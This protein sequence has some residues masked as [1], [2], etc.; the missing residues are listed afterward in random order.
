MPAALARFTVELADELALPYADQ[1]VYPRRIVVDRPGTVN[2][3]FPC[4]PVPVLVIAVENQ[5]VCAW[6]VPLDGEDNPPVLVGGDLGAGT[7]ATV[8]YAADVGAYVRSRR[9]DHACLSSGPLVQAQ[10]QPVDPAS[11]AHLRSRY[12]EVASTSGWPG[13]VTYRF[14]TGTVRIML[15]AASDQCDWWISGT[16]ADQLAETTAALLPYSDLRSS[17]WST[18]VTG[19]ALLDQIRRTP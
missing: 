15:W 2:R 3:Y 7:E 14:R 9:W 6:G 4:W 11:L 5:G 18:D 13:E 19:Q 10:A 16:D 12:D 8:R 17:L 1:V